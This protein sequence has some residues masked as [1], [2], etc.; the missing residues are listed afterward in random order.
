MS[1]KKDLRKDPRKSSEGQKIV[2]AFILMHR[3]V[4]CN[5]FIF[6]GG[7]TYEVAY[8]KIHG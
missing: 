5:V 8:K 2:D 1:I 6:K 3:K 4:R 7:R